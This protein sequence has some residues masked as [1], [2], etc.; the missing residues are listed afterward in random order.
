ME[1]VKAGEGRNV[2]HV[3]QDIEDAATAAQVAGCS[4]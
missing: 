4:V 1:K 2:E 3:A